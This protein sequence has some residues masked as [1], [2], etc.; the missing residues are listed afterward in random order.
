MA[1]AKVCA[2]LLTMHGLILVRL[3]GLP[4]AG[5]SG[6]N[7]QEMSYQLRQYATSPP[8]DDPYVAGHKAQA[9][10]TELKERTSAME[11][12]VQNVGHDS[13]L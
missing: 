9:N 5:P 13:R 3:I 2:D 10:K 6:N 8:R 12:P 4:V 11:G 1:Q 7:T